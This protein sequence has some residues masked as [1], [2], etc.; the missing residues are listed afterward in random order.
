MLVLTAGTGRVVQAIAREL[1]ALPGPKRF[2][3]AGSA[4]GGSVPGFEVVPGGVADAGARGRALEGAHTLVILPTFDPRATEA[5]AVLARSAAAAGVRRILL[6]SL[7]GADARSP[8]CL[9]RWVGLIEREVLASGLPHS[10]LRATPLMQNLALFARRYDSGLAVVGPFRDVGFPWLD[11]ADVGTILARLIEAE[12][13]ENLV[14]QISGP[15]SVSFEAVA[16]LLGDAVGEPVRYVDIC[17]PE[18]QGLLEAY[19]FSAVQV[20]A[21]TE[22]WDYLVS[23]FVKPA[24]CETVAKLLGRPPRSLAQ[25]FAA[26][27]GELRAAA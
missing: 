3:P 14:C 25:H 5:Q 6:G 26:H 16:R 15:E 8:V 21:L 24:C 17:L 10:I 4:R 7:V 19:G 27:A 11:A 1:A 23:G 18:A 20:R 13:P 12:A 9:L 22:Y 2:L